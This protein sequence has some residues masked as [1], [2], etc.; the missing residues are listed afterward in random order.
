MSRSSII[1]NQIQVKS[2]KTT[3]Y[4][5]LQQIKEM[6]PITIRDFLSNN[7]LQNAQQRELKKDLHP[8]LS[9]K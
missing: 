9:K 3:C 7:Y 4:P 2:K 5:S 1:D 8:L 6:K